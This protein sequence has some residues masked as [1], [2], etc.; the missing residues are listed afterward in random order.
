M[1]TTGLHHITAI[2]GDV[3]ANLN[4]YEGFLGQRF[5]KKTVN[6]DDPE[7]YHLYYGD[8]VGTPGTALTFFSWSHLP[9]RTPGYGE[10]SAWYYRIKK[11]SY[12]YWIERAKEFS[13]PYEM[14]TLYDEAVLLL[15]DPDGHQ[16][17]LVETDS[18]DTMPLTLWEDGPIPHEHQLRGFY[19]IRLSVLS[20]NTISPILTDVF[21]YEE[22]GEAGGLTRFVVAGSKSQVVDVEEVPDAAQARQGHGSIHHVAFRAKDDEQREAFRLPLRE[23][24][25]DSTDT[26]ERIFFHATY[27]WTPSG[28]LFEISTDGPGFTVNEPAETL[29]EAM[30]LPPWYE[31]YRTQ[32]EANLPPIT[33]PRHGN[34]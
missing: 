15:S 21:G 22:A 9:K 33:L 26:V 3:Q 14:A 23:L 30:I 18:A 19:G 34:K 1:P 5:I 28:I 16:V 25:V 13:V 6:F 4:F 12:S 8:Y 31:P 11:G 27:F 29:G 32:I 2:T 7:S 20:R 17:Y 10:A 24:G